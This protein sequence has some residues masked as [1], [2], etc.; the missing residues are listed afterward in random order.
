MRSGRD[1]PSRDSP[2]HQ[3]RTR[4]PDGQVVV[5]VRSTGA[6]PDAVLVL[7]MFDVDAAGDALL[8]PAVTRRLLELRARRRSATDDVAL[9]GREADVLR[10]LAAGGTTTEIAA[11]L[12]ISAETVRTH[13]KHLL[14]KLGVRD[15]TQAVAWAFRSGFMDRG[16]GAGAAD[17]GSCRSVSRAPQQARGR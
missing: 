6:R 15:R 2:P 16:A 17:A 3:D 4:E 9:T 1:D 14:A 8:S 5:E 10:A 12:F 13:V 11:T 7:T